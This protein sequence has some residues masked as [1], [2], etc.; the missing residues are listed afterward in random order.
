MIACDFPTVFHALW[1]YD[2]FLWQ[3]MLAARVPGR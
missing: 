3:E 2:P 1:G